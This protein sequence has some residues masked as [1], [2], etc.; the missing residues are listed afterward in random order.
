M[1][2]L[3]DDEDPLNSSEQNVTRLV[4]GFREITLSVLC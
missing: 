1:F 2:E 4:M 3:F